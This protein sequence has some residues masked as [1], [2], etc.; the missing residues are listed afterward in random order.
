MSEQRIALRKL[1][2]VWDNVMGLVDQL[3]GEV[4]PKQGD[5]IFSP[6]DATT[7]SFSFE[8][9]PVTIYVPER[10][11]AV[12]GVWLYI[13]LKG[14]ISVAEQGVR[15]QLQTT[16]FGTEVAYFREKLPTMEHVYGAHYDYAPA[17]KGHPLFHA[18]MRGYGERAL[19]ASQHFQLNYERLEG[20]ATSGLLRTV[21]LPCAQLDAFSTVFQVASDHLI[22]QNSSAEKLKLL[23]DL[24]SEVGKIRGISDIVHKVHS[25]QCMR[26]VHWYPTSTD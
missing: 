14:R 12:S 21:R 24:A 26:A 18:Q 1:V 8:V 25:A 9:R 7:G 6:I 5:Q 3:G 20:D 13:V 15:E 22:D 16:N 23:D 11:S 2:T 4:R 17:H 19:L 10:A